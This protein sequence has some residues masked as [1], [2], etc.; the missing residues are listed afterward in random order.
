MPYLR[1]SYVNYLISFVF[2]V[3]LI[4][5]SLFAVNNYAD[6]NRDMFLLPRSS[7]MGA[8]DY[9]FNRDG[10]NQSNPANLASDSLCEMS[11]AYAGFYQ[12]ALSLSILSYA[13]PLTKCSGIGFSAGYIY[14]PNIPIT[15]NL[16]TWMDGS[17]VIPIY[18]PSRMRYQ[19]GSEIYV[20]FGY[21]YKRVIFSGIEAAGGIAL[22][23]VR[24]NLAPYR[25]YGIG[26][27]GGI[28]LYFVNIGLRMALGFE[29]ITSNYT[30]WSKDWGVTAAPHVRFGIG[31]QNEI[32]YLYGRIRLQFKT[33]D[34]LANEGI[35]AM[36]PDSL[37]VKK[38]FTGDPAYFLSHGIYGIEYTVLRALSLR[39]GIP[40][41]G[42]YGNDWTR[43]AFGGGVNLLKTRLS[44]DISYISHE[45]AGTYQ[46]GVTY[47][48]QNDIINTNK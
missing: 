48:W 32:P 18:D 10:G 41:G 27:D 12:N 38:H 35:N 34:L 6:N 45:L 30:Q 1:N 22:N 44:I 9:V 19:S 26:G 40:V 43:I 24:H 16:Q 25:G 37:P 17:T 47:R 3:I 14:N 36:T 8:S 31:W 5:E 28:A 15:D 33:L 4:P 23:A 29:N 11:L 20:H 13:A 39:V 46:L 21:G 2:C 7:A 42:G